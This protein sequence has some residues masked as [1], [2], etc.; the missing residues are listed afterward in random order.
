MARGGEE[1]IDFQVSLMAIIDS[2]SIVMNSK[3]QN[4]SAIAGEAPRSE[5]PISIKTLGVSLALF[6]N[7]FYTGQD[8]LGPGFSKAAYRNGNLK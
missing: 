3:N 4:H 8:G 1:L 6:P 5:A 7:L 2:Q